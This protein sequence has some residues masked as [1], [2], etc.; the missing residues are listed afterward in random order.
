MRTG[1]YLRANS[2]WLVVAQGCT[3]GQ[4]P[5]GADST[6][7]PAPVLSAEAAREAIEAANTRYA[8]AMI[9]GDVAGLLANY[10]DDATLMM[11]DEP[12]VNGRANIESRLSALLE[13]STFTKVSFTTEDVLVAGDIAI[14]TRSGTLAFTPD[15]AR[16]R[17]EHLRIMAIWRRQPDGSLKIIRDVQNRAAAPSR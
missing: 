3:S 12:S 15:K 7:G 11:P 2:I 5:D 17:I 1:T 16:Q 8:D 6:S 10:R 14:E 9:R 13:L 4:P